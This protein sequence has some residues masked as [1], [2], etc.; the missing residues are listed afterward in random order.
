MSSSKT[1]T[2]IH[3]R[4][5]TI[6]LY[7]I[8][9]NTAVAFP[10]SAKAT[11]AFSILPHSQLDSPLEGNT[12]FDA[13]FAD[14]LHEKPNKKRAEP[15]MFLPQKHDHF[16]V[17]PVI[18][19]YLNQNE[20]APSAQPEDRTDSYSD[21]SDNDE[22]SYYGGV[23]PEEA[24]LSDNP[25]TDSES[26]STNYGSK[27][28]SAC[29]HRIRKCRQATDEQSPERQQITG[30]RSER[31]QPATPHI[32]RRWEYDTLRA[33]WT[34]NRSVDYRWWLIEQ[35]QGPPLNS[36]DTLD[37]LR[38]SF[39]D[40]DIKSLEEFLI[41]CLK[42]LTSQQLTEWFK[43][44][45][46]SPPE[47]LSTFSKS[48]PESFIK[49]GLPPLPQELLN[50]LEVYFDNNTTI[51]IML[52]FL[53]EQEQG[54]SVQENEYYQEL[55][56]GQLPRHQ[57]PQRSFILTLDDFQNVE[58]L[59]RMREHEGVLREVA[60]CSRQQLIPAEYY[61]A[62]L[63]ALI[64]IF[65]NNPENFI[66]HALELYS[67]AVNSQHPLRTE[68]G[69]N[70]VPSQRW[71]GQ[72]F[73]AINGQVEGRPAGLEIAAGS[74]SLSYFLNEHYGI[75]ISATDNASNH[76]PYTERTR[77]NL[78]FPVENADALTAVRNH[79]EANFLVLR[80]P[81]EHDYSEAPNS[82][83]VND[84]MSGTEDDLLIQRRYSLLSAILEWNA[85]G[86]ILFI[87]DLQTG[88]STGTGLLSEYLQRHFNAISFREFYQPLPFN[89]DYPVWLVPKKN[90]SSDKA[91]DKNKD[92][93]KKW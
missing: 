10:L 15:Y 19:E 90:D 12:L 78:R 49:A 75:P 37:Y 69:L 80:W 89:N 22:V 17:Y 23:D 71:L 63:K 9:V 82:R 26:A 47:I 73:E 74:G 36:N 53:R 57:P 42:E 29:T 13:I 41:S 52:A 38:D 21:S 11:P 56:S 84:S 87:G 5:F 77:E 91:N 54:I 92:G 24:S 2:L 55:S 4:F 33:F 7:F 3:E 20:T 60:Y 39:G 50:T 8:F 48:L 79:P 76:Q 44:F 32:L 62:Y 25:A 86:P 27:Q 45:L 30:D 59:T 28:G 81:G 16:F 93:I 31:E 65:L 46:K 68:Y 72:I 1:T 85:R 64:N 51:P 67:R 34:S 6:G 43:K 61:Q 58:I 66:M 83:S 35:V 70:F 14:Y 18:W 40:L 88:S